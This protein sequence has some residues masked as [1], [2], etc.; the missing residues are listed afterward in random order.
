MKQRVRSSAAQ[1]GD[2]TFGEGSYELETE[3]A[4]K[5]YRAEQTGITVEVHTPPY[6]GSPKQKCMITIQSAAFTDSSHATGNVTLCHMA[7]SSAIR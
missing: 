7:L 3:G 2:F 6:N 5:R 1:E 4:V